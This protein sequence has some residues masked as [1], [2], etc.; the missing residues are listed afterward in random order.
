MCSWDG[1]GDG[2]WTG[3]VMGAHPH[4]CRFAAC[5]HL[6]LKGDGGGCSPLFMSPCC[7]LVFAVGGEWW[8]VVSHHSMVPLFHVIMVV[9][10]WVCLLPSEGGGVGHAHHV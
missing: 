9:C 6:Q 3:M 10:W 2:L 1:C 7:M 5:L 8:W 4:S